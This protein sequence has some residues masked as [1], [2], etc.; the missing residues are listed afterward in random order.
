MNTPFN[1]IS[2]VIARS[3]LT[4]IPVR[5]D[6]N[7]VVIVIPADGPSYYNTYKFKYLIHFNDKNYFRN[8]SSREMYMNIHF[9]E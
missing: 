2:P 4:F 6:T 1:E 9:I 8:C 5:V 7:A 3:D